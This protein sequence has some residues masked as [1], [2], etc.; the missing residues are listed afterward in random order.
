MS[1][2]N[3]LKQHG[4]SSDELARLPQAMIMQMAQRKE[5]GAEM[6][7]PILARKAQM[8]DAVARTKALQK[9]GAQ[10]PSIM[11]Q[12]MQKT[13]DQENPA[14]VTGVGVGQLP[15]PERNYA[16]GGIV[17]FADGGPLEDKNL[18]ERLPGE[19]DNAYMQRVQAL[20]SVGKQFFTP[21]NYNPINKLGDLYGAY[22]RNIGQPFAEGVKRF[23]NESRE[24]Q[25][26]RFN[27]A[28]QQPTQAAAPT[29]SMPTNVKADELGRTDAAKQDGKAATSPTG[30]RP[31]GLKALAPASN[32]E[33]AGPQRPSEMQ[34]ALAQAR[35]E[36]SG[37]AEDAKKARE[38]AKWNRLLEAGLNVMG[39]Q[40]TNFAQNLA[41]AGQAAKGYGEDVKGLRTEETDRRKQLAAL[42]LK[43]IE[44]KQAEKKGIAEEKYMGQHGKYFE[45]MGAHA[46][47]TAGLR[48]DLGAQQLALKTQQAADLALEKAG[49]G[50]LATSKKP[51]KIQQAAAMKEAIYR[52]Y[53]I[54]PGGAAAPTIGGYNPTTGQQAALNKYLPQ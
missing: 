53:G 34:E 33:Q 30:N 19:S 49:Y 9:G 21:S 7:A 38:E 32:M 54:L 23:T 6:V 5:I 4:G 45:Q 13:A 20:A 8:A 28:K 1:I 43:G 39:G 24:S 12:L 47:D 29:A 35:S 22:D 10:Q 37:N 44:L 52:Q 40:S 48:A 17:A 14:E 18:P 2:L 50:L 36:I 27:A 42:N 11:E 3:A 26:A 15:I 25:A 31:T 41:L 46:G 51:E 16:G